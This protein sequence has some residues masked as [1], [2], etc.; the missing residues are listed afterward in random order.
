MIE[1]YG[2]F[3][4]TATPKNASKPKDK[5]TLNQAKFN[6]D[7]FKKLWQK[8]SSKTKYEIAFNDEEEIIKKA[9]AN[10]PP[11]GKVVEQSHKFQ[12][13]SDGK[14]QAAPQQ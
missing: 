5:L 10:Q 8:I 12:K 7:D 3:D 4:K 11:A 9:K 13:G 6:S 14:P 1:D 2:Y